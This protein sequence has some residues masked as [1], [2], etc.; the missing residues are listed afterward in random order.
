MF[1]DHVPV[2]PLAERIEELEEGHG[3]E[4]DEVHLADRE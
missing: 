4:I 3:V 1:L 2:A